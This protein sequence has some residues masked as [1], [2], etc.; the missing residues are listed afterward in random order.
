MKKLIFLYVVALLG[1][2]DVC[3]QQVRI[4]PDRHVSVSE[5]LNFYVRAPLD[6]TTGDSGTIQHLFFVNN[7]YFENSQSFNKID[8]ATGWFKGR[9]H[10]T[11]TV[12]PG[13]LAFFVKFPDGFLRAF[14]CF[15]FRGYANNAIPNLH[16][17]IK[18]KVASSTF[19]TTRE[20]VRNNLELLDST[21]LAGIVP[22]GVK[23]MTCID[24]VNFNDS[25]IGSDSSFCIVT[26]YLFKSPDSGVTANSLF[27]YFIGDTSKLFDL[28]KGAWQ[29][30]SSDFKASNPPDEKS[31]FSTSRKNYSFMST[32][33]QYINNKIRIGL[34]E[35]K[36]HFQRILIFVNN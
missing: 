33:N 15:A 35:S 1:I 20:S 34:C 12:Q 36:P 3:A 17:R 21:R 7:T 11:L 6:T 16:E 5:Q 2:P 31:V 14:N 13:V 9:L 28:T 23:A 8:K 32:Q 27:Q 30:K 10:P 25:S 18:I 22:A 29:M 4:D 24:F 26:Q 19:A